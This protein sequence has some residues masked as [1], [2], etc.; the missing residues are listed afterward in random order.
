MASVSRR[1]SETDISLTLNLDGKGEVSVVTE[2]GFLDH[3]LTLAGSHGGF[4]LSLTAQGDTDVDFHHLV[5]DTGIC[6]GQAVD[7][8]L[9]D[10]AGIRRFADAML[11]MDEAL[12]S[13]ALDVSGRSHLAFNVPVG[14]DKIGN[15]DTEVIEEFFAAF[16]RH[17]RVTLHI[18]LVYGRNTH[19]IVEAVFKAFGRVLGEAVSLDPGR[20]GIPSTKGIL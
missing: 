18:N 2:C 9:G 3:M 10:R 15:L 13:A 8:A 12:V 19:H 16:V 7:Q 5:E 4:D 11:P 6:M 17:A 14:G 1:T 20:P